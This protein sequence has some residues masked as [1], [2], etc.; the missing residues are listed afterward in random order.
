MAKRGKPTQADYAHAIHTACTAL[1]RGDKET[2]RVAMFAAQV[3][4]RHIDPEPWLAGTVD[5]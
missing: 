4:S 5:P 2:A 3:L 1:K